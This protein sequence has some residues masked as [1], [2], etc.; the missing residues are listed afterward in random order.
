MQERSA[1]DQ[2]FEAISDAGLEIEDADPDRGYIETPRSVWAIVDE[3]TPD[4]VRF[5]RVE[6]LALKAGKVLK[7]YCPRIDEETEFLMREGK[8]I[9]AR[10]A[11]QLKRQLAE[12]A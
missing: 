6:Q 7:T 12:S 3:P 4:Y 10:N 2:L 1:Y 11:F 9:L 5:K 8:M